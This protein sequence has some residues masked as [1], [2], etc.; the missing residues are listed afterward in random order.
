MKSLANFLNTNLAPRQLLQYALAFLPLS[1]TTVA[2]KK[3]IVDTD[4]YSDV[5]DAGALLLASTLPNIDLLAVNVNVNSTYSALAASAILNHYGHSSVP[6]GLRRPYANVSFFDTW[7]YSL[8]EYASKVAYRWGQSGGSVP[9]FEVETAWD[10]VELYRTTL[11]AAEDGS[12]TIASIGFLENLSGLLNSTAD[13]CSGLN[14]YELVTKKVKELVVMGGEYPSG[15]EFNFFGDKPSST[16]HVVNTWPRSV[17]ITFLGFEIGEIV[18]TGAKLSVEGPED[19]PVKAA[20]QWYVGYNT[21]RFSWDP[22]TTH[23]ACQGLGNWF[24][25]GNE[26]G[27][28]YVFPNGSNTWVQDGNVTNQHYLR[29]KVGNETVARELDELFLQGAREWVGMR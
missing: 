22:L 7:S 11:S 1:T 3:L 28:N 9:W 12:I 16:A 17:P 5:D 13:Q 18:S 4:I 14:G 15:S 8:G 10:A 24:E 6:I 25:Y 2:A 29:L 23:Y 26:G 21:T 20:Y 19:D 27:Y